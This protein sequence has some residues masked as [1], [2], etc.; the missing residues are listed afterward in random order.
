M[1]P[2]AL[3]VVFGVIA[4]LA[5]VGWVLACWTGELGTAILLGVGDAMALAGLVLLERESARR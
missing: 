2:D 4:C 3:A 1:K 5:G